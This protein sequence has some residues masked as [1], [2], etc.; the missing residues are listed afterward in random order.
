MKTKKALTAGEV[1]WQCLGGNDGTS[2]RLGVI[3]ILWGNGLC[4]DLLDSVLE[5]WADVIESGYIE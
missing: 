5:R 3:F 4:V 2:T 1:S